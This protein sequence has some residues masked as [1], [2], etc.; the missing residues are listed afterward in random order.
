MLAL[1]LLEEWSHSGQ[2]GLVFLAESERKAE[3]IG[4]LLHAL[5]PACGVM[6]LPRRDALPFDENGPSRAISG[7]RASVVRRLAE[8]VAPPLL[9]S[10]A[11]AVSQLVRADWKNAAINLR[12]GGPFAEAELR[13]F[14]DEAGYLLDEPVEGPGCALFQGQVIE[15]YPAGAVGPVRIETD[16]D[17]IIGIRLYDLSDATV[18]ME[19]NDLTVDPVLE[20]PKIHDETGGTPDQADFELVCLF[21]YLGSATLILDYGVE[22]RGASWLEWIEEQGGEDRKSALAQF[23]TGKEWKALLRNATTLNKAS[24]VETVPRFF[25][26]PSPAKSLRRFLREADTT[27]ILFTAADGR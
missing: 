4:A 19:M 25:E 16:E 6:V 8:T 2:N 20:T 21:S 26:S 13:A 10:T 9:V 1:F 27:A 24:K 12:V 7:R 15:L 11:E 23:M 17:R 22:A 3:Q 18:T 5:A 14:L